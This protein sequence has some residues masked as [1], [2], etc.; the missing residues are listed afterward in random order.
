MAGVTRVLAV[1]IFLVALSGCSD[2]T[3][4]PTSAATVG[5]QTTLTANAP[6]TS[7]SSANSVAT[8]ATVSAS[9]T[10]VTPSQT[11]ATSV[12]TA[13]SS[14]AAIQVTT[15]STT[16]SAA[17]ATTAGPDDWLMYHRDLAHTGTA[18]GAPPVTGI[19][20]AWHSAQLDGDVYA[21]PLYTQ[22]RV[23]V[24][25]SG[26]SVYALDAATGKT[27]W[28]TNIGT[29]VPR[30]QLPCGNIQTTGIISTPVIDRATNTL[31]AVGFVQ[32]LQHIL[33]ALNLATGAIRY[34]R[35]LD[36][37][38]SIPATQQ[39]RGALAIN[40]GMI[41]VP[42]GG[43]YGDCG[44][45]HGWV[46]AAEAATGGIKASYQ[47]PTQREGAIWGPPGPAIDDNGDLYVATGNGSSNGAFDFGNTVL[48]LSPSLA[49]LD[50]F[51][52]TNWAELN[53]TDLDIGSTSPVLLEG[54]LV[55]QIGKEGTGYTLKRAAL[56]HISTAP[57]QTRVCSGSFG[58]A[59][60]VAPTLYLPCRDGIVAV[61]F[62][63]G[64]SF[65]VLWHSPTFTADTP[66][67]IGGVVWVVDQQSK[68]LL[69]LNPATGAVQFRTALQ[70]VGALPHFITPT[71][72]N[73]RLFVSSGAQ[74][75][76]FT[77]K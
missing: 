8:T 68:D 16:T 2:A 53:T 14:N 42:F 62:T 64:P 49:V 9:G 51:A 55:F 72:G 67:L 60:Y 31:F 17:A 7:P 37:P 15:G 70:A 50:W 20:S 27:L 24:A 59:A 40:A 38:S 58:G 29:P 54:G 25:T 26:D 30:S 69:G 77:L 43:L 5:T 28:R 39:Q 35:P 71:Y 36:P 21:E 1:L 19:Q 12:A 6:T 74:V 13:T 41:Y 73:G 65:S 23:Y 56:G 52:P 46:V 10:A 47:V 45:Y 66:I 4:T 3:G 32:P 63:S 75:D 22:D 11:F 57:F 76:A 48:R 33:V 44:Q 34:T 18:P 61:R